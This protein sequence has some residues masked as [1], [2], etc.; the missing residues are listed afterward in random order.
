MK[1]KDVQK[2][3][4]LIKKLDMAL[5]GEDLDDVVPALVSFTTL[6]C[7]LGKLNKRMVLSFFADSLDRTYSDF[8]SRKFKERKSNEKSDLQR[9]DRNGS[10]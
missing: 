10:E 6:A 7:C 2:Y 1:I 4:D 3:S 9:R 5:D 8:D